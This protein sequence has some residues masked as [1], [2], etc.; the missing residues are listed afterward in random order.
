MTTLAIIFLVCFSL[1]VGLLF[2]MIIVITIEMITDNYVRF[3]ELTWN[4]FRLCMIAL[5]LNYI[6]IIIM[7]TQI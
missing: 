5:F 7:A 1:F 3:G 6:V 2:G 4:L